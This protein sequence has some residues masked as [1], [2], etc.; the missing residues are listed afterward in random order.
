MVSLLF[1]PNS[2]KIQNILYTVDSPV[3]SWKIFIF[4]FYCHLQKMSFEKNLSFL[5]CCFCKFGVA[6]D[7]F[8]YRGVRITWP[9]V[10]NLV[11]KRR[12]LS[13]FNLNLI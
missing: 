1:T 6:I 10:N 7:S 8:I 12:Q 4:Q 3:S 2:L 13:E 11:D 9:R 5:I